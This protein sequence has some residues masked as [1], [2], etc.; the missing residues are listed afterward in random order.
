MIEQTKVMIVEDEVMIATI[1]K[2]SLERHG[3]IV[4]ETAATGEN[5]ITYLEKHVPEILLLDIR[6]AGDMSG[7]D[8]AEHSKKISDEIKIIFMTGYTTPEIK[9]Q[10]MTYNPIAFLEKPVVARDVLKVLQG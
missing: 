10:A 5:A 1:L 9:T 3:Y 2:R 4:T 6:L 8:V 7:L